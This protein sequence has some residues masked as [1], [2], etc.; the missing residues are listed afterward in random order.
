V[1]APSDDDPERWEELDYEAVID[2]V[3]NDGGTVKVDLLLTPAPPLKKENLDDGLE[4]KIVKPQD[5]AKTGL[6]SVSSTPAGVSVARSDV[7]DPPSYEDHF[8][9]DGRLIAT[10]LGRFQFRQEFE[11]MN[12]GSLME[13]ADT[14]MRRDLKHLMRRLWKDLIEIYIHYSEVPFDEAAYEK[15]KKHKGITKKKGD[16]KEEELPEE[17]PVMTLRLF[18]MFCRTCRLT[19]TTFSF[20]RLLLT[21]FPDLMSLSQ[22]DS[23]D[24]HWNMLLSPGKFMEALVRI[25]AFKCAGLYGIAERVN[26]LI[27]SNVFPFATGDDMDSDD[28]RTRQLL[29]TP[30]VLCAFTTGNIGT[31]NTKTPHCKTFWKLYKQFFKP[32]G[33]PNQPCALTIRR[34]YLLMKQYGFFDENLTTNQFLP[35]D[36]L[37]CFTSAILCSSSSSQ[38]IGLDEDTIELSFFEFVEVEIRSRLFSEMMC[39]FSLSHWFIRLRKRFLC[40]LTNMSLSGYI[41]LRSYYLGKWR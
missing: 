41:P 31:G 15:A 7:G 38:A 26:T 25:A 20:H 5:F 32:N 30:A 35:A 29:G 6:V 1:F 17:P 9:P 21:S 34:V 24:R 22:E 27:H 3:L 28:V 10:P 13:Q 33:P 39:S 4:S 14:F 16:E 40:C 36:L 37:R 18:A 23:D 2:A 8:D 12:L 19:S 11:S